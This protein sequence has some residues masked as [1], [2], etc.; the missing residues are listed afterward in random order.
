MMVVSNYKTNHQ[1]GLGL[2]IILTR[3]ILGSTSELAMIFR[4]QL[5]LVAA[6]SDIDHRIL[7]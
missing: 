4:L 5:G 3:R 7:P 1:L 6:F 2:T